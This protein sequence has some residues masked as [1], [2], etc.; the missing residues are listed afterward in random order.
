LNLTPAAAPVTTGE[1]AVR[2]STS[3]DLIAIMKISDNATVNVNPTSGLGMFYV[4]DRWGGTG[5]VRQSGTSTVNIKS[6][7]ILG[8]YDTSSC[9][10]Y[11]LSGGNL[12]IGSAGQ[13]TAIGSNGHGLFEMSGG[14]VYVA[15]R[16]QLGK[17]NTD[18]YGVINISGGTYWNNGASTNEV[19]DAGMGIINISGTGVY[20]TNSDIY[21]GY[22]RDGIHRGSGIINVK[23][24]GTLETTGLLKG[25]KGRVAEFNFHGGTLKTLKSTYNFFNDS[26]FADQTPAVASYVYPEGGIIDT[27]GQAGNT[28]GTTVLVATPLAAPTGKGL[29]SVTFDYYQ[30][31]NWSYFSPPIVKI[32]PAAGDSTGEGATAYA[33]LDTDPNNKYRIKEIVITNPGVNYTLPPVITLVGGKYQNN[34]QIVTTTTIGDNSD[35]GGITKKGLGILALSAVNTYAGDTTI[36]AGTLALIDDGQ[37]NPTSNIINNAD[38]AV[39]TVFGGGGVTHTVGNITG[40]GNTTVYDNSILN[41]KSIVQD[42]LTIGGAISLPAASAVPEPSSIVLLTLA[43]LGLLLAFKR[44]K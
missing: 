29:T 4:G 8:R 5:I 34:G 22:A 31:Q 32:T 16:T 12:N 7:L 3:V 9:G 44:R 24:G 37:L 43:G 42:T 1:C 38:F 41:A 33:V 28:T 19:G 35:T 26:G 20:H 40:T 30:W 10:Y 18:V 15:T 36:E 21:L 27:S 6:A 2:V 23:T 14:N 13:E 39:A 11:N 25:M 17:I